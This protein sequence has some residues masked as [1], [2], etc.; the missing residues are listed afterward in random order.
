MAITRG[1]RANSTSSAT[2]GSRTAGRLGMDA[3]RGQKQWPG[4]GQRQH[5]RQ[6]FQGDTDAQT[7][8]PT[9]LACIKSTTCSML[10]DNCG[11]SR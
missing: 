3:N 1:W 5:A 10:S 6:I 7:A 11:K 4:L 2:V 8:Q 9:P